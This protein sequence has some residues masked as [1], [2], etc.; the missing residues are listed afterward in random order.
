MGS[1]VSLADLSLLFPDFSGVLL[2][3]ADNIPI[4]SRCNT[5]EK[6]F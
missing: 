4:H 1:E 5:K 2:D 6:I 3:S